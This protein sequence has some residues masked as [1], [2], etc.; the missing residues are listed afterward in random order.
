MNNQN[1]AL[2]NKIKTKSYFYVY[3]NCNEALTCFVCR[4]VDRKAL[5]LTTLLTPSGR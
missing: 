2:F 4:S 1:N 5:F 3:N